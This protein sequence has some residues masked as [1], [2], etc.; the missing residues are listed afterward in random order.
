M[1]GLDNFLLYLFIIFLFFAV[2]VMILRWVLRVNHIVDRLDNIVNALKVGFN[3][4]ES[5]K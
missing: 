1:F 5:K 3:I 4:E 2:Q